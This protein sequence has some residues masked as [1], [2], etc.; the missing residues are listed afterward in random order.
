MPPIYL[1]GFSGV[2][3]T[4]L[5]QP[6]ARL[7]DLR[8][9]DSDAYIEGMYHSTISD[10]FA[11]CGVEKFRKREAATL[12]ALAR[13][14]SVV[15]ATGGGLITYGDNLDRM[16]ESGLVVYLSSTQASLV[17]RLELCKAT[18]PLVAA[19]DKEAIAEYVATELPRREVFY[20]QA[21]LHFDVTGMM[22]DADA[23]SAAQVLMEQIRSHAR[24]TT[25]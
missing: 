21:H 11:T 23:E 12:V 6:L 16:L 24:Y 22:S 14:R 8:F 3:K 1:V 13:M 19:L 20:N 15:I 25:L 2:G 18:R 17:E 4:Q 7:M 5:G 10:M 9:V